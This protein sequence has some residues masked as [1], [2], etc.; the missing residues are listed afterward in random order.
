MPQ[1][2]RPPKGWSCFFGAGD[3]A[4][5]RRCRAATR[6][7]APKRAPGMFFSLRSYPFEP[8]P[9]ACHKKQDHPK[10]G[11]V[12]L[13]RATRLELAS[14]HPTNGRAIRGNP[15]SPLDLTRFAQVEAAS[16]N[17]SAAIFQKENT[18]L[19]DGVSIL[20]QA[21]R[22]ARGAAAPRHAHGHQNVP[23][24]CFSRCARTLSSLGPQHATKNKTTQRVVL[25]FWSGRRGSNSL[26]GIPRMAGPFAGTLPH[27]LI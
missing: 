4:R 9:A 8:R 1:K 20:E 7:R 24:A 23:P 22:L 14:R 6:T 16:S 19:S 2:T 10:G 21:T 18:I 3:E 26:P 11:L 12:F 27:L 15:A 5:S 13:E 17:P 25:F